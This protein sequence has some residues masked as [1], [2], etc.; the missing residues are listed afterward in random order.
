MDNVQETSN[1]IA[2]EKVAGTNVFNASGDQIGDI[3]DV[4]LDKVSGRVAYA[5]M[6]FGGFLGIGRQYHPVPWSLLK[7]DRGLGGYVVDLTKDQLEAAPAY[8]ADTAPD[9]G[10]RTYEAELHRFYGVGPYWIM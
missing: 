6:S 3:H 10:D 1:L 9:W 8:P 5:V 7:Y 2:S 4:M